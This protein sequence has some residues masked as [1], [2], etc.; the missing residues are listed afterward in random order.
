MQLQYAFVL[1]LSAMMITTA[2]GKAHTPAEKNRMRIKQLYKDYLLIRPSTNKAQP[3][4]VAVGLGIMEVI[5]IDPQ[6]QV[7]TR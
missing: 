3:T 6:K 4:V 1:Y 7:S 2:F 5:G